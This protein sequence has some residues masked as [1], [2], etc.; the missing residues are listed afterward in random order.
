MSDSAHYVT[1]PADALLEVV[2][3]FEDREQ[4]LEI[5][6]AIEEILGVVEVQAV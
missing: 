3:E 1:R 4:L 6:K 5:I 2:V